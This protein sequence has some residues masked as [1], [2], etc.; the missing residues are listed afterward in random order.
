[1][2]AKCAV[3]PRLK[4]AEEETATRINPSLIFA[5]LESSFGKIV[6]AVS[7]PSLKSEERRSGFISRNDV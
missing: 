6:T 2:V 7:H 1:V 3:D 5:K 4:K